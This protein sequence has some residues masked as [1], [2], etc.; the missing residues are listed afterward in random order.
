VAESGNAP[1][2]KSQSE[3]ASAVSD[4]YL[5]RVIWFHSV[6]LGFKL[7]LSLCGERKTLE[8]ERDARF[9]L[10]KAAQKSLPR[11]YASV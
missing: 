3:T 7:F 10:Q 11:R 6:E 5:R 9:F 4:K 1:D 2:S 8:K